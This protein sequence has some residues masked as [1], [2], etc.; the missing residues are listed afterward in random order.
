MCEPVIVVKWQGIT[1]FQLWTMEQLESKLVDM[2]ELYNER[3]IRPLTTL[4]CGLSSE[5]D[6]ND[7]IQDHEGEYAQFFPMF[8]SLFV[9]QVNTL[10]H[11]LKI[12]SFFIN[13][14]IKCFVDILKKSYYRKNTALLAWPT[15]FWRCFSINFGLTIK[16]PS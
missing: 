7:A 13:I 5:I 16:C 4:L 1:G 10:L 6:C 15:Y 11:L 8:D 14:S 3:Q 2:R 12:L 9:S